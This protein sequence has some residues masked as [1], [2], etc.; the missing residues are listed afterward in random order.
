MYFWKTS[1]GP[2]GNNGAEAAEDGTLAGEGEG[3]G[4]ANEAAASKPADEPVVQDAM[5]VDSGE[6]ASKFD[7]EAPAAAV[8]AGEQ[9]EEKSLPKVCKNLFAPAAYRLIHI[10]RIH[11]STALKNS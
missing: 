11:S 3:E 5:I 2:L 6:P 9:E 4:E 10:C 1:N 7:S 8:A